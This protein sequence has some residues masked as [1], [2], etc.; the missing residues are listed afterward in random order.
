M[1][2]LSPMRT[3]YALCCV[4][5]ISGACTSFD[6][7]PLPPIEPLNLEPQSQAPVV[8]RTFAQDLA[9]LDGVAPPGSP[10]SDL[11]A[12]L[13]LVLVARQQES[14]GQADPASHSWLR[15]LEQNEVTSADIAFESWIRIFFE[16]QPAHQKS[17]EVFAKIVLR[18]LSEGPALAFLKNRKLTNVDAMVGAIEGILSNVAVSRNPKESKSNANLAFWI[19]WKKDPLLINAAAER[20]RSAENSVRWAQWQRSLPVEL[21]QHY[22]PG[23]LAFCAENM[24]VA[25]EQLELS[26]GQLSGSK[27]FGAHAVYAAEQLAVVRRMTD[28]RVE[29]ASAYRLLMDAW[30]NPNLHA[31]AF[32]EANHDFELRR[33]NDALWAARY[34]SL[35]GDYPLA[36]KYA[37]EALYHAQRLRT[38]VQGWPLTKRKEL[39][40]LYAE[41]YHV[42]AFRIAVEQRDFVEAVNFNQLGLQIPGLTPEWRSRFQWYLGLYFYLNGDSAKA[43]SAWQTYLVSDDSQIHRPGLYY[44]LARSSDSLGLF[45]DRDRFLRQLLEEYPL[46]F[47][48]VVAAPKSFPDYRGRWAERFS[49]LSSVTSTLNLGTKSSLDLWLQNPE[50]HRRLLRSQ[51]L[52]RAE[53]RELARPEV[54]ELERQLRRRYTLAENRERYVYLAALLY[55]AGDH[56]RSIWLLTALESAV[57]GFWAKHHLALPLYFPRPFYRNYLQESL[58]SGHSMASLLAVA[59]QES[60]FR[61]EVVSPAGAV[62][63]MQIMPQTAISLAS[64]RNVELGSENPKEMLKDASLNIRLGAAYLNEL[65]TRYGNLQVAVYGAYNAGSFSMDAWLARRKHEDPIMLTELIPYGETNGYVKNVWRNEVVYQYL[66]QD[67]GYGSPQTV[68]LFTDF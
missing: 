47:Y 35:I 38:L 28:R 25:D 10:R 67:I 61:E 53:L 57:E 4:F 26:V 43:R 39:V 27:D 24:A 8:A 48:S 33:I 11:V 15:V 45:A 3:A 13:R 51:I 6:F 16:S 55:A 42:L 63:I 7:T 64:R 59:R 68:E 58:R 41:A 2:S 36:E 12:D 34:R 46:H 62:G 50:I 21:L 9:A 44:W 19:S 66:E 20:C 29:V 14:L 65:S 60:S 22:W 31:D 17:P 56:F 23:I 5:A 32:G 54:Q 30:K 40:E 52:L 1:R 49:E 18:R 37:N